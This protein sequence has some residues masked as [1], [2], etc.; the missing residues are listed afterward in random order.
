MKLIIGNILEDF[1]RDICCRCRLE[2]KPAYRVCYQLDKKGI[3]GNE[4]ID[5][6]FSLCRFCIPKVISNWK[7]Y[8]DD[9]SEEGNIDLL[10]DKK[11][12]SEINKEIITSND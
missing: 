4:I 7:N 5:E 10:P 12:W 8:C 6:E 1:G 3:N 2:C 11:E 9:V